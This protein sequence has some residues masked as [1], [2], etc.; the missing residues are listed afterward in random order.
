MKKSLKIKER[1]WKA[2]SF[3]ISSPPYLLSNSV[4]WGVSGSTPDLWEFSENGDHVDAWQM[5][6]NLPSPQGLFWQEKVC[7]HNSTDGAGGLGRWGKPIFPTWFFLFFL[8]SPI[9]IWKWN[10]AWT[11]WNTATTCAQTTFLVTRHFSQSSPIPSSAPRRL[12]PRRVWRSIPNN[13]TTP[14]KVENGTSSKGY[15]RWTLYFRRGFS[16]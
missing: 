15:P 12:R 13:V 2:T 7:T 6:K 4:K 3:H 11:I 14:L 16:L 9:K 8:F 5:K 1:T 10:N